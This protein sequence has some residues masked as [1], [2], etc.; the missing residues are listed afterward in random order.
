M[1]MLCPVPLLRLLESMAARQ[2][3]NWYQE[4]E[5]REGHEVDLG[6]FAGISIDELLEKT[7]QIL[8]RCSVTA[9]RLRNVGCW[10]A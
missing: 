10:L 1:G 4:R 5:R 6:E 7:F 3:F 2:V 9:T 8:K